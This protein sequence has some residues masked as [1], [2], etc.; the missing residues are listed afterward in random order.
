[1]KSLILSIAALV[2]LTL[3][4]GLA[5]QGF[6]LPEIG[7][8]SGA[9]LSPY[10]A[11]E[12]GEAFFRSVRRTNRVIDDPEIQ[13]YISALGKRL[14]EHSADSTRQFTFFMV[15][16]PSIN[17][18]AAPGGFIGIHTGLF[19][20]SRTESELAGVM[21]HEIAHVTQRHLARTFERA[22]QLKIPVAAA[23]LGAILLGAVNPE[24]AQAA[25]AVV[26]AGNVQYQI[27]FT[28]GNEQEAD[29]VGVQLLARAGF[30]PKGMPGFFE[31]LQIANRLT[32]PKNF[33]EFL[34]THPVTVSRIADSRNRI[35]QIPAR[36]HQDTRGY[37]LTKTR[38]AVY[39]GRE[40]TEM[41]DYLGKALQSGDYDNEEFTRY[42]YALALTEAREFAKARVQLD[43]LL[44]ASPNQRAY[45]LAGARLSLAQNRF[46]DAVLDYQKLSRVYPT[47]RA[48]LLGYTEALI[49]ANRSDQA[50]RVLRK[51]E[52]S[53]A[54]DINYYRLVTRAEAQGGSQAE[55]HM[56][57]AEVYYLNGETERAQLQLEIAQQQA[58][59]TNYQRQRIAARLEVLEEE[60]DE[61]KESE[62]EQESEL[63][64]SRS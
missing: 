36:E 9:A 21:A 53:H 48:V 13:E 5:A 50:I 40:P 56:A 27:N 7:D 26:A 2:S 59:I 14:V 55:S 51:Y 3:T 39:S 23:L 8:P 1:M 61:K 25:I 31:R 19:L 52:R 32:D 20:N 18:F 60:L 46:G 62:E 47:D 45:L 49:L 41:A 54:P 16:D 37:H 24:A 12:L 28:R 30:D 10:K 42:G 64:R 57:L 44:K 22:G 11:K 6:D 34:R 17:A 38:I 63:L 4:D 29:R 35:A 58:P 15:Q 43:L 33:P